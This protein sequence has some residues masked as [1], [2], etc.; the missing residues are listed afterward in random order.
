M[1]A[2]QLLLALVPATLMALATA[3]SDYDNGFTEKDLKYVQEFK[4]AY[5]DIDPDQDWNLAER[6]SVTVSTSRTSTITIF[7]AVG[8]QYAIVGQ[9]EDISGSQELG[10]DVPEG[11]TKLIVSD[12]ETAQP[13]TPGGAVSFDAAG[14]KT[15]TVYETEGAVNIQKITAPEGVTIGGKVYPMYKEIT[16]QD[17]EDLA[18]PHVGAV[19]EIG[20]G[21]RAEQDGNCYTNLNRVTHDFSYVST[22]KFVVYPYYWVTSNTNTIGIYYYDNGNLVELP[23]Y[24]IK[25]GN[26]LQYY[27]PSSQA[28]FWQD[29]FDFTDARNA[30]GYD[31]AAAG[32]TSENFKPAV[33]VENEYVAGQWDLQQVAQILVEPDGSWNNYTGADCNQIFSNTFGAT[34]ARGQGIVVD[35]P[36][37]TVFGMYLQTA[38]NFKCYSQS[39]LNTSDACGPGVTDDGLNLKNSVKNDDS[40]HPSYASTFHVGNQMFLGFE[41]WKNQWEDSDMDFNDVVLAFSGATPTIINEDPKPAATWI[42]AC[43]DLGGTFDYDFNDVVLK[44]EH[45]SGKELATIT[46]LAAGGT[47]ASYLF[48]EDPLSDANEVS[49]GEIHQLFGRSP[50]KSGSYEPINVGSGRRG[51][52][53]QSITFAVNKNWTMAYYTSENFKTSSQYSKNGKSINMGGF[54]IRVL[55]RG[56]EPLTGAIVSYDPAFGEASVV[57][58]PGLGNVP[59]MI[60]IPYSFVQLN[61]PEAGKQTE[62]VWA[63]P[64]EYQPIADNKGAGAYPQFAQWVRDYTKATDW[65]KYPNGGTVGKLEFV[66]SMSEST[67]PNP[68]DTGNDTGDDEGDNDNNYGTKV[69]D[70]ITESTT[71]PASAFASATTKVYLTFLHK[72]GVRSYASF[73]TEGQ[74]SDLQKNTNDLTPAEDTY[75]TITI[76]EADWINGLKSYGITK[77]TDW[78]GGILS[79]NIGGLWV[80]CE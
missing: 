38:D 51:A 34:V 39:S 70:A 7:A 60:C 3:C 63:W 66:T 22:G 17:Y 13:T 56:A 74:Y 24:S 18:D 19:P 48:F 42:L 75:E 55:P 61:T 68:D 43:E 36:V 79:A 45:V 28:P 37:G 1:K 50:E 23:L 49:F 6:T 26:E 33:Y 53:G 41:D 11:T 30:R 16:A 78:N 59:E 80:R 14:V 20:T 46:P 54:G 64:V 35:I 27:V 4:A 40:L 44:I 21:H 5:G 52:E 9:Y 57:A 32:Y 12:G 29:I 2:K 58:A 47:L 8:N 76:T 31:W 62:T 77:F 69:L 71:V 10:I 73:Y 67:T 15:R 72:G 65:Y 25:S